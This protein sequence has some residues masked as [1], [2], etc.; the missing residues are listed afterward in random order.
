MV[1]IRKKSGDDGDH[2]AL[3]ELTMGRAKDA[4]TASL[5][6]PM[7]ICYHFPNRHTCIR[8]A[9]HI[10]EEVVDACIV[11]QFRMERAY[12]LAV[13]PCCHDVAVDNGEGCRLRSHTCD[14]WRAYECHGDSL[15]LFCDAL[16]RSL[17]IETAELSAIC[18]AHDGDVH[19]G[20]A[21]P[22]VIVDMAGEEYHPGTCP[23]DWQ[24]VS[25]GLAEWQ[26][27]ILIAHDAEHCGALSSGY[28][29]PG[30]L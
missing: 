22:V 10:E 27:E 26:E 4:S 23:E 20:E 8:S 25:Y 17:G 7:A 19:R 30:M 6:R 24:S 14:I 1:Y 11:V 3:T 2:S 28:D 12:E 15:T 13:L 9:Y 16:E 29:E 5:T 21:F 18:V